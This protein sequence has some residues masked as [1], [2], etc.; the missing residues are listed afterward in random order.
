VRRDPLS[1]SE[2]LVRRVYA[3]VAARL[4]DGPDAEDVTSEVFERAVRYRSGYDPARGEPIDWLIGIARRCVASFSRPPLNREGAFDPPAPG[5]LAEDA[6]RRLAV[7]DALAS[8]SERDRELIGLY[9]GAGLKAWQIAELLDST[10]NAVQVALHRAVG[11]MRAF[12]EQKPENESPA[13]DP[14]TPRV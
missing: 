1:N 10:T 3:Y 2:P 8:L 14:A 6:A 5:D 7:F 4:G 11:R 9:Y 12:V 13:F